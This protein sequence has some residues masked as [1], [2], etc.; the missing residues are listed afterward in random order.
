VTVY[1]AAMRRAV[2]RWFLA[3]GMAA[4]LVGAQA[5]AQPPR[6]EEQPVAAVG[7]RLIPIGAG[8]V[9]SAFT[10]HPLDAPRPESEAAV[11]VIHGLNRDADVYYAAMLAAVRAAEAAGAGVKTSTTLVI[12]PQFLTDRDAARHRLG[13]DVA[14]WTAG[15]WKGGG[16]ALAPA[17]HPSSFAALDALLARL[18]D[19]QRFPALRRIVIAGHSA[20]AQIVHRYAVVGVGD[21]EAARAGIEIRYV[22]ANPSSYLYV[23]ADRPTDDGRGVAPYDPARCLRFDDYRYGLRNPPEYVTQRPVEAML[24]AYAARHVVYLLGTADIDP[25]HRV[26]DRS[27]AALAQGPH[28][29]ARGEAY[30]RYILGVLGPDAARNHRKMLVDGVGHDSAAM[31]R[32]ATGRAALFGPWP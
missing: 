25:H 32:S 17:A 7:D 24:R 2:A 13:H 28:R 16:P 10:S 8:A 29:L 20:G 21:A 19:R 3:L 22:V 14:Y 30:H 27:C 6:G 4:L 15:G 12:A 5:R 23:T 18:A 31:F 26:L 11:I 1:C 9:L